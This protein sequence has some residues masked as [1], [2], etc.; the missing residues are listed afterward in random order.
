MCVDGDNP[1]SCS[2][3]HNWSGQ[4][5]LED[6]D[7][8]ALNNPCQN[9]GT[10][11]NTE[12]GYECICVSRFIGK[13]CETNLENESSEVQ[14]GETKNPTAP[15]ESISLLGIIGGVIVIGLVLVVA[16]GVLVQSNRRKT[17]GGITWCPGGINYR[18]SSNNNQ[19]TASH[20]LLDLEQ[21][22]DTNHKI[23]SK[24]T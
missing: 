10:C 11:K 20:S 5:C 21:K 2:C 22:Q 16:L 9:L 3:P 18:Q 8:C 15:E 24:S 23:T 13:N 17:G 19:S 14:L 7:E 1:Y 4:Y 6:V 12:G